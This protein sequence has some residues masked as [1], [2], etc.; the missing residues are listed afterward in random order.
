MHVID[1]NEKQLARMIDHT[2]LK[3]QAVRQDI[4]GLCQEAL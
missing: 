2:L 1:M 4:N 3:A